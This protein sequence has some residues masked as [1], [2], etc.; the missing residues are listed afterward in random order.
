MS[1][2]AEDRSCGGVHPRGI[3]KKFIWKNWDPDYQICRNANIT[4]VEDVGNGY[5]VI[6]RSAQNPNGMWTAEGSC[7]KPEDESSRPFWYPKNSEILS[8]GDEWV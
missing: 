4:C 7:L 1:S 3:M 5:E 6:I 2:P 8:G